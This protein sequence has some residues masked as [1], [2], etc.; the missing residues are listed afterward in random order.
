MTERFEI[1]DTP[2]SGLAILERRPLEDS[3]GRFERMFCAIELRSAWGEHP[4]VQINL[5]LTAR[6]GSVRGMH[7]QHA[8]HRETKIVS[9][10]RGE[11]FDVAVDL[12]AESA[13]FLQWHGEVLSGANHR[14]L[15]IPKGF[16]HGFQAL[17]DDC[18]LLYLHDAAFAPDSEGGVHPLDPRLAI[19]WPE[20]VVELSPR[21]S[22]H[23]FLSPSF[24]GVSN[25]V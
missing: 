22:S 3:R 1:R 17:S 23:M 4:I 2:L 25:E 19:R 6:K 21:D 18:E 24:R 13:T 11:V 5:S 15:L 16:A 10:L 14:S 20:P 7:F 9:C 12:R 8:P